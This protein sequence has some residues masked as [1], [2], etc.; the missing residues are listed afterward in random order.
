MKTFVMEISP[1]PLLLRSMIAPSVLAIICLVILHYTNFLVFHTLVEF[2]SVF[3]GLMVLTLASTTNVFVNNQFIIFIAIATGWTSILDLGHVFVYK[4]LD[5]LPLSGGNAST[6]FWISA[7]ILQAVSFLIA[8]YFLKNKLNLRAINTIFALLTIGIVV[9]V[10]FQYFPTTFLETSGTTP[11]KMIGEFAIIV[12]LITSIIL[13]FHFKKQIIPSSFYYLNAS[14]V[15]MIITGLF[16]SNYS[17]LYG[18]ENVAGHTVKIFSYWFIYRALVVSTINYP[19]HLLSKTSVPFT[20]IHHPALIINGNGVISLANKAAEQQT[21]LTSHYLI[22]QAHHALF[23]NPKIDPQECSVCSVLSSKKE[24]YEMELQLPQG[25]IACS[26]SYIDNELFP[27]SWLQIITDISDKKQLELEKNKLLHEVENKLSELK[28]LGTRVHVA[29]DEARKTERNFQAIIEQTAVGVYVRNKTNFLYVNPRFCEMLGRSEEELLTTKILDLIKDKE[30]QKSVLSYWKKL[31]NH[32]LEHISYQIPVLKKDGT[33]II[34]H[35]DASNV[36]WKGQNQYLALVQDVTAL[37]RAQQETKGYVTQLEFAIKG[38]F[39]A[40]SNMVELRDPY[41]AGHE[42][43]V[44]LI[45]KAIGKELNLSGKTCELLELTGLV[46]DIGKIAI[47]S[48]ILTKPTKLNQAE[49]ELVKLHPQHGYDILSKIAFAKPVADVILQHHERL[50]G[51]GY[52]KGLKGDAI[53]LEARILSVADVLEAMV[54][55][56]PYRPALGLDPAIKELELGKG[57]LYDS[58]A[59]DAVLKVIKKHP[60]LLPLHGSLPRNTNFD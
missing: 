25:W 57:I 36:S 29:E 13:M 59:V 37:N 7:R 42:K 5:I 15:C 32:T 33:E 54:S 2:V 18:F 27:K 53:S 10:C 22:G 12:L 8:P 31:H 55:H 51:S 16:L 45:A 9:G 35:I 20:A 44:G 23:H 4:G 21:T 6:Q 52:P 50:D 14:I 30:T 17:D 24:D 39:T 49:W 43:R 19:F 41:T 11:S 58:D 3:I 47:P 38:I 28:K 26:L 56:R 1:K 46:H 60:E 34:I 40:V 48:E